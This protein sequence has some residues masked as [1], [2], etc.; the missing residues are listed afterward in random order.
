M[1]DN[2]NKFQTLL[3]SIKKVFMKFYSIEKRKAVLNEL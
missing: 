3:K 1:P 2:K